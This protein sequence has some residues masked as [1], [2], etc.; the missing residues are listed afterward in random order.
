MLRENKQLR[1]SSTKQKELY[2]RKTKNTHSSIKRKESIVYG[3][4]EKNEVIVKAITILKSD[5]L[6][7]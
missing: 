3:G 2:S 7:L 1:V 4:S 6:G 5:I